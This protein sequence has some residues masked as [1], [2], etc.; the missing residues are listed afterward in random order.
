MKKKI[1]IYYTILFLLVAI[2]IFRYDVLSNGIQLLFYFMIELF[3]NPKATISKIDLLTIDLFSSILF[4]IIIPI[5]FF[6]YRNKFKILQHKLELSSFVF[7]LLLFAV[8]FSPLITNFHPNAQTDIRATRFLPPFSTVKI[9]ELSNVKNNQS[10]FEN[11]KNRIINKE[12]ISDKLFVN[13]DR[14][15]GD[16]L[17]YSE[18]NLSKNIFIRDAASFDERNNVST[19]I[20]FLGTDELGRDIFSRIVY[21]ARV[22]LFIAFLTVIISL[23]IGVTFGFIAANYG[24]FFNLIL[25]RVTDMFLAIPAI[26]FVIMILAFWGNSIFAVIIVLGLTGWMSI[27]KVVK[28]EVSSIINKDYFITSQKI[29]LSFWKLLFKEIFPVLVI[30]L[31]VAIVFQFSNV[32]LAESSLSYLGLGVGINY[33]SWG[34][35]I[36]SGQKYM[37]TAWWMLTVPSVILVFVL[38]SINSFGEKIKKTINPTIV[39]D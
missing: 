28:G 16:T 6:K 8:L 36:L 35:M 31:T 21:G 7:I 22:S 1:N 15:D 37:A 11:M 30:S 9:I 2:L 12:T 10:N 19:K 4:F 20:Y 38:L 18:G 29:G 14:V 39:D 5:V 26:F 3:S 25:S 23:V 24:G 13:L 17:F 34:N 33:P 27:F 32:I